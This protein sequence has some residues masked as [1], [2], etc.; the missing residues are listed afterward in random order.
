MKRIYLSLG[1]NLGD[2]REK[3]RAAVEALQG[4]D[5]RVLRVSSVY[6]TEPQDLKD[7]P[8]FLNQVVEAET[9]LF[10]AQ[11]LQRVK[12]IE[13]QLGRK[14][15]VEKGPRAVDID[16]LFYSDAVVRRADLQIPH[17]ALGQRR[18]VLEPLAELA[19]NLRHPVTGESVTQMLQRTGNQ[20]VTRIG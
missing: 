10:P 7:Q 11:L 9:T 14:P 18:F 20:G 13:V 1:S 3:L 15:S 2:R 19:P 4:E 5:L 8:W 16:I 17:A 12:K 6:E